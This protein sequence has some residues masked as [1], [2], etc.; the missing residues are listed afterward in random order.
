MLE[1]QKKI[2]L[3]LQQTIAL[4]TKKLE[5]LKKQVAIKQ[6]V[7]KDE[8]VYQTAKNLLGQKLIT[9][10]KELGCAECLNNIY[11]QATGKPIGGTTSTLRMYNILRTDKRFKEIQI[12]KKGCVIISPTTFGNG[13]IAHGHCGIV[14]DGEI[15]SNNS[16]TGLLDIHWTIDKWSFYYETKGGFPIKFYNLV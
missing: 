9:V 8:I 12:P 7:D 11:L 2:I 10:E 14:G 13:L 4:L 6:V 5:L 15:Y 16:Q 1:L 3:L